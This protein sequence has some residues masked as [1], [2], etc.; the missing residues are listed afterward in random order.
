MKLRLLMAR[1]GDCIGLWFCREP[2]STRLSFPQLRVPDLLGGQRLG[3]LAV[4]KRK[5]ASA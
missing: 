2:V 3:Q 4:C 5:T 1:L